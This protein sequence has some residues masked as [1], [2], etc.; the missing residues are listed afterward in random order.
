MAEN[1]VEMKDIAVAEDTKPLQTSAQTS[2]TLSLPAAEASA[3]LKAPATPKEYVL[4]WG[5][6]TVRIYYID[7]R[8]C[9]F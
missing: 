3:A 5:G 9:D 8:I 2:S 7:D 4:R 1:T 6:A